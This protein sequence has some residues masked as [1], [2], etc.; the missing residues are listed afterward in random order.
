MRYGEFDYWSE[1]MTDDE[2]EEAIEF[3]TLET[4]KMI[5]ED[6]SKSSVINPDKTKNLL[7][8]YKLMKYLMKDNKKAKVTCEFNEPFNSMGSVGVTGRR[9][10][11]RKPEWF[12]KAVELSD[13]FEVYPK[14]DGTVQMNFTFHGLTIPVELQED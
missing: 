4:A 9:L 7:N 2:V 13:N 11:F 10:N 6:E 14:A 12:M 8:T 5:A 3:I 1:F